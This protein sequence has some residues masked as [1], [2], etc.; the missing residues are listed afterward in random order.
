[1]KLLTLDNEFKKLYLSPS[2][3]VNNSRNSE[4]SDSRYTG[5]PSPVCQNMIDLV[6]G[7]SLTGVLGVFVHVVMW[8]HGTFDN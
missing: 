4:R 8:E 3:N 1:M 7:L 5:I 6:M 2:I